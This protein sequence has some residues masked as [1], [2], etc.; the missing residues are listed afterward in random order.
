MLSML[1]KITK[2]YHLLVLYLRLSFRFSFSFP[3]LRIDHYW[4]ANFMLIVHIVV[5]RIFVKNLITSND[6]RIEELIHEKLS[7]IY[8]MLIPRHF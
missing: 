1:Q 3:L 6:E 5:F 8:C 7:V 4:V 2:Y